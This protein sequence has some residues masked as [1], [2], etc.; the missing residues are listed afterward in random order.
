[1]AGIGLIDLPF[2]GQR[3]GSFPRRD[4][5]PLLHGSKAP[6]PAWTCVGWTRNVSEGGACVELDSRLPPPTPMRLHFRTDRGP[7]K[8]DVQVV[9]VGRSR[10]AHGGIPHGLTFTRIFR[11]HLL[12]LGDLLLFKRQARDG[13]VRV[14]VEVPVTWWRRDRTGQPIQLKKSCVGSSNRLTTPGCPGN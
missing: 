13:G 3:R 5:I 8:V 2:L 12:T 1:M 14:P 7:I 10:Q 4:H 11:D 9:W 6:G